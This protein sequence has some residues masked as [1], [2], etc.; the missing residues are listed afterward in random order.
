MT[1]YAFDFDGVVCDSSNETAYSG[2]KAIAELSGNFIEPTKKLLADFRVVRPCL[3]TGWESIF[4]VAMLAKG[5][6]AVEIT[7]DYDHFLEAWLNEHEYSS[8]YLKSVYGN[9]RD[10]WIQGDLKS[11]LAVHDFYPHAINFIKD[12]QEPF[13]IIT[14][15]GH[16]FAV[17][18]A[19]AAG[20]NIPDDNI[21]GLESGP[22][23]QTLKDLRI[24]FPDQSISFYEDRLP[25]LLKVAKENINCLN[26]ILV[27]WGYLKDGDLELA[28]ANGIETISSF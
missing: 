2:V 23:E 7:K 6:D 14:T 27:D 8:D 17:A 12:L 26:L 24:K 15:K 3:H 4:I 5:I 25:T 28:A 18:L 11:W 13:Y 1:I 22:K 20:I 10:Q 19:N 9:V 21:F 16:R